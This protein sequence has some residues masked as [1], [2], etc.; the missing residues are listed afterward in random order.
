[1]KTPVVIALDTLQKMVEVPGE[2]REEK[3]HWLEEIVQN[4]L[5]GARS[6]SLAAGWA[7]SKIVESDYYADLDYDSFDEF[8]NQQGID[9]KRD[10]AYRLI[11]VYRQFCLAGNVPLESLANIGITKLDVAQRYTDRVA[12]AQLVELARDNTRSQLIDLLAEKYGNG[13][14]KARPKRLVCCPKCGE[15]FAP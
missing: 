10:A 13:T 5:A 12:P 2:T 3:A 7:M 15:E 14:P 9:M 6:Y 1:M 8:L 4:S 11:R